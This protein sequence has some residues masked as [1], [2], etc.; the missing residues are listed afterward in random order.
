MDR[1]AVLCSQ[2]ASIQYAEPDP[3]FAAASIPNDPSFAQE[4]GLTKI[5]APQAWDVTQGGGIPIAI[6][7]SGIDQ[8]HPAQTLP[9]RELVACGKPGL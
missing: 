6:L 1:S 4:W 2:N 7:D 5:Q 9:A 3:V 8:N